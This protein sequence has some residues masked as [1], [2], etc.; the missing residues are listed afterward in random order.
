MHGKNK[1]V[2]A[3]AGARIHG[4]LTKVRW[5]STPISG[6]EIAVRFESIEIGGSNVPFTATLNEPHL[7]VLTGTAISTS[8][9]PLKQDDLVFG[10]AFHFPKE[11]LKL[12]NLD[13]QW[14]TAT[15]RTPTEE[16]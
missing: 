13:A 5:Q 1:A 16:K 7:K 9:M 12:K 14:V 2:I 4:R 10:G 15:P 3:P 6:L 11:H 8:S